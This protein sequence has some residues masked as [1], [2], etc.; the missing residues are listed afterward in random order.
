MT[1]EIN[2]LEQDGWVVESFKRVGNSLNVT[3][4]HSSKQMVIAAYFYIKLIVFFRD[5]RA[6]KLIRTS[7]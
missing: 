1:A 4:C 2:S 6:I 3:M 7:K 5:G